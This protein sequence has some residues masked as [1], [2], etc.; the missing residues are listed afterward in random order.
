M[1]IHPYMLINLRQENIHY[2]NVFRFRGEFP[3][4]IFELSMEYIHPT[5]SHLDKK[6]VLTRM[7]F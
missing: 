3:A 2:I 7:G 6:Y 5:K 1:V 4:D